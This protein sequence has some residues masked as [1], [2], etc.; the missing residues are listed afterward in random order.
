MQTFFLLEDE[1]P[2]EFNNL[3]LSV[4]IFVI[5]NEFLERTS[6]IFYHLNL[7]ILSKKDI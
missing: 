4:F 3:K 1:Y 5:G 6:G 2:L 7:I